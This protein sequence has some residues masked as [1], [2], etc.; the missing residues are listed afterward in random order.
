VAA[1]RKTAYGWLVEPPPT[2]IACRQ[3]LPGPAGDF[4]PKPS[5]FE[6]VALDFL[7][8]TCLAFFKP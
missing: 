4:T 6:R 5:G 8:L 1:P 2:Q 7:I 3:T